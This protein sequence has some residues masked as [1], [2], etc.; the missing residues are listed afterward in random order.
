MR[1]N[2]FRKERRVFVHKVG[3]RLVS[4]LPVAAKLF[5]FAKERLGLFR[6]ERVAELSD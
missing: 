6:V 4:I 5:E 2:P 1:R 3:R